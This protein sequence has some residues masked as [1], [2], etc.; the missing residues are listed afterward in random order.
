MINGNDFVS[1][2]TILNN[3]PTVFWPRPLLIASN[4]AKNSL[5]LYNNIMK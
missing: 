4:Y 1:M 2:V 5:L 3:Y